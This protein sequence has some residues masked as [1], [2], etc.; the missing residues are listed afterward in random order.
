M[1]QSQI[2]KQEN[3]FQL[4]FHDYNI[5]ISKN[6]YDSLLFSYMEAPITNQKHV[7]NEGEKESI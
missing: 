5:F 4:H 3:K 7:G 2:E 6:Q 1:L